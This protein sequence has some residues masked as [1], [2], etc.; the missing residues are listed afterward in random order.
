M[1][2]GSRLELYR[3]VAATVVL[4]VRSVVTEDRVGQSAGMGG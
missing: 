3:L 2:L 1:Y 4:Q